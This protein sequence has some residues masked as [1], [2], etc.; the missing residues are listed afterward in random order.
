MKDSVYMKTAIVVS[1]ESNCVSRKVGAVIVKNGRIV[2][3]GYN[4]TPPGHENCCDIFGLNVA[5]EL[6]NGDTLTEEGR[7]LHHEWSNRHEI[8]AEMNALIWAARHGVSTEGADIFVTLSP[9]HDCTKA[10]IAAGI[11]RLVYLEPYDKTEDW[12]DWHD[13]VSQYIKV[14]K[15]I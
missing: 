9:C 15:F 4:G 10:I 7:R 14:E 12:N 3:T 13:F 2:S 6:Y 11:K 1:Q 8:H 5:P